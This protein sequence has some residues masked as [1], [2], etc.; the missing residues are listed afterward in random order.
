[1]ADNTAKIEMTAESE[2]VVR[3]LQKVER[4]FDKVTDKVD[5][6]E[7][8]T[9]K[10]TASQSRMFKGMVAGARSAV[11]AIGGITSV[12]GAAT[13]GLMQ[14]GREL[15]NLR[16]R[17]QGA[18]NERLQFEAALSQAVI[19]KPAFMTAQD[20]ERMS[21]DMAQKTGVTPAKAATTVGSALTSTGV[22]NKRDAELAVAAA[23]DAMMFAP[24]LD[25][26][27]TEATAGVAASFAKRFGIAPSA[28]IGFT[29]RVGQQS[30]VRDL[31]KLVENVAP[32]VANLTSFGFSPAESGS[33]ISTL[34]QG[35]GDTTGEMSSTAGI[36]LAD[37]LRKAFPGTAPMDAMQRL[38]DDREAFQAFFE[39]GKIDGRRVSAASLGK[40]KAEPTI[41]D[42]VTPGT[43]W[44]RQ[45][46]EGIGAIGD[47]DAGQQTFDTTREEIASVTPLSQIQ[48]AFSSAVSRTKV[49]DTSGG[50]TAVSRQGLQDILKATG[51][52][53]ASQRLA[54]FAFERESG[55][56]EKQPLETVIDSLE[57][58]AERLRTPRAAPASSGRFGSIQDRTIPVSAEDQKTA[59]Q[60]QSIADTLTRIYED[61]RRRD[62]PAQRRRPAAEALGRRD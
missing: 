15:E 33:L 49:L 51:F 58:R 59:A 36:A 35:V 42:I 27:G 30:N 21:L 3:A 55:L 31:V 62:P 8:E 11:T 46:F 17:Q 16:S 37:S 44:N 41:R 60:L 24:H 48:R 50:K 5:R 47:F 40:G 7:R 32:N 12:A 56:T 45:F 20:V 61:Q 10:N 23:R 38:I 57:A 2:A 14:M 29:Q 39:G 34:T 13:A 19:N 52:G 53:D 6:L 22:Q 43:V 1:M 4:G 54:A 18:G 26:A 25:A 28:A 9:R